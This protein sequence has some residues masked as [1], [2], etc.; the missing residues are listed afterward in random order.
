MELIEKEKAV[1]IASG[2]C[3]PFNI[4]KELQQLPPVKAIPLE[5]I[6]EI[7][8]NY[9]RFLWTESE[10]VMGDD[11]INIDYAEDH[12]RELFQWECGE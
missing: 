4:A 9:H 3:N 5:K 2:Y 10:S 1:Y 7:L 8:N 12:L 11:M 6:D